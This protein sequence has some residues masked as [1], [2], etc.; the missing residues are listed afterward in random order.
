MIV[1]MEMITL[2]GLKITNAKTFISYL[3]TVCNTFISTTVDLYDPCIVWYDG[4]KIHIDSWSPY[5]LDE[6]DADNIKYKEFNNTL[7][8]YMFIRYEYNRE[9]NRQK[10]GMFEFNNE[11]I[12]HIE[13]PIMPYRKPRHDDIDPTK[14]TL[15]RRP[16]ENECRYMPVYAF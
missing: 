1:M 14:T 16:N 4:Y 2:N 5:V 13:R 11:S 6:L 12:V 9:M 10:Y 3:N 7:M 15:F 8:A